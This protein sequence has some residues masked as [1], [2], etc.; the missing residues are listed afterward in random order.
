MSKVIVENLTSEK[1]LLFNEAQLEHAKKL[2][3]KLKKD[4]DLLAKHHIEKIW[5]TRSGGIA[6]QTIHSEYYLDV[7]MHERLMIATKK[8]ESRPIF[9]NT[10]KLIPN[11]I[12]AYYRTGITELFSRI[13]SRTQLK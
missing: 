4:K 11:N 10:I 2:V 6:I 3:E 7:D 12:V 13:P 1:E 5:F 9:M 8:N